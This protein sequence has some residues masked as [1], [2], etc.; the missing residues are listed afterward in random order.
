MKSVTDFVTKLVGAVNGLMEACDK[1][2]CSQ[3]D[4]SQNLSHEKQ[5]CDRFRTKVHFRRGLVT[6]LVTSPISTYVRCDN[7]DNIYIGKNLSCHI[8]TILVGINT[9]RC[10]RK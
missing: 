7:C 2:T 8:T 10:V 5:G 1:F 4:L 3:S 6:H 9:F